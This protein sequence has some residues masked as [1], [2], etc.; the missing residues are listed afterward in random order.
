MVGF[1]VDRRARETPS[2]KHADTLAD[3]APVQGPAASDAVE[4]EDA[5][6]R[7]EHVGDVVET[8][9][10]ETV[11]RR[12]A[13]DGEDGGAVDGDAGNAD[14]FLQNLQ[15]NDELDAAA[16]VELARVPA[17]EH[18]QVAALARGLA[19]QLDDVADVLE[20]G[21]G[22]AVP[23]AAE[24]AEDVA[25][26]FLA[27]DFHEPA[28]RFGHGPN[29]EEEEDEGHDL[30]GDG[31]APNEGGVDLPVE[32]GAVFNP[33][34]DDDAENVE[35]EFDGDELA[36]RGVAGGFGGPD[37]SD[38]VEDA[39]S[40]TVQDAGAEHPLGVLSGALQGG[41]D[42]GPQGSYGYGLDTTVSIAEPA[43]EECAEEGAGEVVD[44]DLESY[45][46]TEWQA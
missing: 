15:P 29:D 37:G 32:G 9:D 42:D 31:E 12:N 25:G 5:D 35:G 24:A 11:F 10:P 33:V 39:G 19:L 41:A 3:G 14:P 44:C 21:L 23:F 30:E 6:Q 28:G 45:M 27:A 7:R 26:L 43:S 34:G 1:G 17:E 18:C 46:S 2:A 13:G 20:L 22:G 36:A 38:G 8:G 16:G 40:D 4:S